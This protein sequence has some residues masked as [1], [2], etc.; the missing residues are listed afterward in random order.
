LVEIRYKIWQTVKGMRVNLYFLTPLGEIA[1]A[2]STH[3]VAQEI[4]YPGLYV[5]QCT[6]PANLLN[7]GR[8]QIRIGAGIPGIKVLWRAVDC[9]SFNVDRTGS[10]G[11]YYPE[12]WPGI[13][14]PKLDWKISRLEGL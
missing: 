2:S 14:C 3:T 13:V 7:F 9:I 4:Q 6:I 8:Y 5:A 1:F 11:S 10:Q 12:N